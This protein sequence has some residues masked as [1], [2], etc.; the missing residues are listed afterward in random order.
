MEWSGYQQVLF[1][2]PC[3]L[4]G[5]AIGGLFDVF[6]GWFRGRAYRRRLF[7]ADVLLGALSAVITFFGALVVMD[8]HLHPLLFFG[9]L[10]GFLL[11]HYTV[12]KMI[13]RFLC[14]CHCLL[15]GLRRK[16]VRIMQCALAFCVR[17]AKKVPKC[18][19][20]S[21]KSEINPYFFKKTL[22]ISEHKQ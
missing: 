21:E 22:D 14:R 19:K 1:L 2:A 13:G 15:S 16:L 17:L 20:N 8:G 4:I 7:A 5:V 11:E 12:G 18:R 3:A 9:L 6:S 10:F